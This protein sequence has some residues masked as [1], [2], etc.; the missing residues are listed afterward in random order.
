MC[1]SVWSQRLFS[2]T[3]LYRLGYGNSVERS[4]GGVRPVR[5]EDGNRSA[6]DDADLWDKRRYV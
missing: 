2:V 4:A 6:G 5:S 3:A 1:L